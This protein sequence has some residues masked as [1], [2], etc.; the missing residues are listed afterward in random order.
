MPWGTIIII[1]LFGISEEKVQTT[2]WSWWMTGK[3][4]FDKADGAACGTRKGE[5]NYH[6]PQ[7][8]CPTSRQLYQNMYIKSEG[9]DSKNK[10]IKTCQIE[11]GYGDIF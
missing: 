2:D 8:F 1:I 9:T 10:F 3:E 7:V 4:I 11:K 5:L 6:D